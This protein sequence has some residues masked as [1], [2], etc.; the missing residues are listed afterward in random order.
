M[1]A[2]LRVAWCALVGAIDEL[3]DDYG[4]DSQAL[5]TVMVA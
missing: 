2:K 4:V 3:G 1:D 5:A